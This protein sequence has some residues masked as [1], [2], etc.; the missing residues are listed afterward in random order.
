MWSYD[1]TMVLLIELVAFAA[2]KP[3]TQRFHV[4]ESP[5]LDE[6]FY[7]SRLRVDEFYKEMWERPVM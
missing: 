2:V 4:A 5:E 6:N 3:V 1:E 7:A